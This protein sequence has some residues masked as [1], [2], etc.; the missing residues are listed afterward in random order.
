MV[1]L[2]VVCLLIACVFAHRIELERNTKSIATHNRMMQEAQIRQDALLGKLTDFVPVPLNQYEG[3]EYFGP[4]DIG[5][6]AQTFQV[7]YD[8]GSSNLWVPSSQCFT[9]TCLRHNRYNA[10]KSSTYKPNGTIIELDYGSGSV[11]GYFSNDVVG[12]GA[13]TIVDQVQLSTLSLSS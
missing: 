6:P 4:V 10:A 1:K 8:T 5:T 2:L 9:M 13:A 12:L 3:V 11:N 7:V